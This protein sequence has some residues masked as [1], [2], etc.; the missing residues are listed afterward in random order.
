METV[1]KSSREQRLE[2]P[3]AELYIYSINAN[4]I[5]QLALNL[6]CTNTYKTH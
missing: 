5:D 3:G 6:I 2:T 4:Q 1:L